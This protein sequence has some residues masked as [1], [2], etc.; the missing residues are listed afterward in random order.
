MSTKFIYEGSINLRIVTDTI[1]SGKISY[2]FH[3]D[4]DDWYYDEMK[5]NTGEFQIDLN[6]NKNTTN[7]RDVHDWINQ[8]L[9]QSGWF[10]DFVKT[11][12]NL[13]TGSYTI[14]SQ[15]PDDFQSK[16]FKTHGGTFPTMSASP[17]TGQ[18]GFSFGSGS[19]SV[20]EYP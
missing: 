6:V 17:Y 4:V 14:K 13:S 2:T 10:N 11:N 18:W 5:W 3:E 16:L 7:L 12:Y 20:V 9:S 1:Q 19:Y 15:E 8:P